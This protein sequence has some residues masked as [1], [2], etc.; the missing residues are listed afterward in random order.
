ML[1]QS[2]EKAVI[3]VIDHVTPTIIERYLSTLSAKEA[4]RTPYK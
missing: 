4:V 1:V 2:D 3:D